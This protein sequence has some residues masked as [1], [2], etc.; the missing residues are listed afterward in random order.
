MDFQMNKKTI[1]EIYRQQ[2]LMGTH[3]KLLKENKFV[4]LGSDL[5]KNFIRVNEKVIPNIIDEVYVGSVRVSKRFIEDIM[6]VLDDASLFDTFTRAEKELFGN[7]VS[8]S[9]DVVDD[10]Y[11]ILIKG[12]SSQNG[13]TEKSIIEAISKQ[14]EGGKTIP[15]VLNELNGEEDV[16]LNAVL[17]QKISRKIRD[18]KTG[19]FNTEVVTNNRKFV[20]PTTGLEWSSPEVVQIQKQLNQFQKLLK[21]VG[22]NGAIKWFKDNLKIYE[23]FWAQYIRNWYANLLFN[24]KKVQE[25]NINK[26]KE[27]IQ[28]AYKLEG[29][30][31]N[32]EAVRELQKA[33]SQI[34]LFKKEPKTTVTQIIK[35]F[36]TENPN[37]STETKDMLL[38][39]SAAGNK[40]IKDFIEAISDD[41]H[42]QVM[43]PIN[44][45]LK[46]FAELIPVAGSLM[47]KDVNLVNSVKES[48]TIP[49]TRWFNLITWKDPRGA[50]EVI[51]AMS[52]R[53]VSKEITAKLMSYLL[54]HVLVI[55]GVISLFK[56]WGDNATSSIRVTYLQ[57]LKQLCDSKVLT[58][59]CEDIKNE[60]DS[61]NFMFS[62]DYVKNYLAALPLD[63]GKLFGGEKWDE[64][65]QILN[66]NKYFWT[67]WDDIVN[68][69]YDI[70][71][72]SPF[73]FVGEPKANKIIEVLKKSNE[74]VSAELQRL[75]INPNSENL[76]KEI[77][78][79][80]KRI[81]APIVNPIVEPVVNKLANTEAGFRIFCER[82]KDA[83]F[84]T[85]YGINKEYTYD[86]WGGEGGRTKEK[87]SL[88]TNDWAW[89]ETSKSF[90]PF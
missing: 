88:D 61:I 58:D 10:I 1:Y 7:I 90:K 84:R 87:N 28:N 29:E 55:P 35:T 4:T 48:V 86:G 50:F 36:I 54:A 60:L 15:E 74:K 43:K 65:E 62:E 23:P 70:I 78:D 6:D 85:K 14:T 51:V 67:Y 68:S 27:F 77:Q 22:I 12:A 30:G 59:G 49:I 26:A 18:I 32:N 44:N 8:Q 3:K 37:L 52:K 5:I 75:G 2:K 72:G 46:A 57:A 66:E 69:I 81:G 47:K 56:T 34:L 73:P 16:F 11:E 64:G 25:I 13:K 19:K 39:S 45:E 40:T 79:Y 24:W 80:F 71:Q 9:S 38:S 76:E 17:A 33:L 83:E 41:V 42:N 63:F 21:K 20:D 82:T 89:D 31:R 53:G